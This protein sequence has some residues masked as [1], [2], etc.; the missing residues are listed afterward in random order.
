[1]NCKS[2]RNFVHRVLFI[3]AFFTVC[4]FLNSCKKAENRHCFKSTGSEISVTKSLNSF[5]KMELNELVEYVLV[6]DV[7]NKIILTGG[8][9]LLNEIEVNVVDG[10]L[11]VKNG[12]KCNFLR[13]YKKKIKAEI[14]FIDLVDLNYLGTEKLTNIDTL[15]LNDFN[16]SIIHGASS[17]VNLMMNAQSIR[18]IVSGGYGDFTFSG[19]VGYA[20]FIVNSN[21]YCD[22]YNLNVIDSMTVVSNTMG[23]MKIKANQIGL[24]A[25]IK[26]GGD[27]W[28][29]GSPIIN[30]YNRYGNG[31][32]MDKN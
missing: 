15:Q 21:G 24:R 22:T 6:Q 29:K 8:K 14:H 20:N 5:T 23:I 31:Q 9:N 28:Y 32:L 2:N 11:T 3:V 1:M 17:S 25:E 13:S 12:N 26:S 7:E 19:N 27:I 10:L 30:T 4:S 18:A 16:L